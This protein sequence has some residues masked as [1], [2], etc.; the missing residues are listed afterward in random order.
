MIEIRI[1]RHLGNAMDA[2]LILTTPLF[3]LYFMLSYFRNLRAFIR[4]L[5]ESH[6]DV[7]LKLG[8]PSVGLSNDPQSSYFLTMHLLRK[9][10]LQLND[11]E[12]SSIGNR[13]RKNF[14][15]S[16]FFMALL[17]L[18]PMLANWK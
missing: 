10:Y 17:F 11:Q 6:H 14:C 2:I 3:I 15:I 9:Q 5:Q 18:V 12:L 7:W 13:A 16:F 4:K 8:Q 1:L